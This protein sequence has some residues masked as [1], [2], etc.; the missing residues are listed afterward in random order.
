M[1]KT[2]SEMLARIE[3]AAAGVLAAAVTLLILLNIASRTLGMAIYWIDELTIYA[4]IWSTFLAS[5]FVLKKRQVIA[6]TLFVDLLGEQ[7]KAWMQVF[8]DLV[9][10]TF[11]LLLLVLCWG[12]FEPHTLFAFKFD[13]SEFQSETFNYIYSEKTN[14]L[15]I[16]KVW[17]WLIL[18]L[19]SLSLT[20]HAL[21]NLVGSLKSAIYFKRDLK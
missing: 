11:G 4:M 2:F 21:V 3:I 14:T 17:P 8:S 16:R 12:W 18:P 7:T 5:S 20:I 9:I 15:G 1:L 19:F 10:L 13:I 6:V